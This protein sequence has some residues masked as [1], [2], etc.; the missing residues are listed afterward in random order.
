M[1]S[2]I[3]QF[4]MVTISDDKKINIGFNLNYYVFVYLIIRAQSS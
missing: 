2:S 1:F 4:N 3:K